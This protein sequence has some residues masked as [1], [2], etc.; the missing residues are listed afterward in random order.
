M[1]EKYIIDVDTG[2][3]DAQAI[4]LALSRPEV[5]VVAIT[6]VAGNVNVD[7]VCLNTLKVLTVCGRLDVKVYKGSNKPLVHEGFEATYF[8][9]LDGLGDAKLDI[10][11]SLDQIQKEHAVTAM[12]RLVNEYPGEITL[13][14]LAPLTNIAIAL[15]QDANFGKKLK[16]VTL[17]GG[18][19]Q[20]LV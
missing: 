18:N 5:E 14:A 2:V 11:V 19:T 6:C 15:K 12:L 3:D 13:V 17:M 20:G 4:M 10:A 1:A 9:G 8:H 16:K 7:Q